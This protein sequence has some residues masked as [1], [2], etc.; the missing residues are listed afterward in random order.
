MFRVCNLDTFN[1]EVQKLMINAELLLSV[2]EEETYI[3]EYW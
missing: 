2:D 3:S 1:V